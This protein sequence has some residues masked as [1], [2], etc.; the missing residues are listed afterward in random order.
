MHIEGIVQNVDIIVCARPRRDPVP[1]HWYIHAHQVRRRII[2]DDSLGVPELP[3]E[4]HD[5]EDAKHAVED[6]NEETW[7]DEDV[8]FTIG[9]N[10]DMVIHRPEGCDRQCDVRN[11]KELVV[12]SADAVERKC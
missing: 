5:A 3:I 2:A 9:E 6:P 4:C 12:G 11:K 8:P 1:R 7:P 10:L